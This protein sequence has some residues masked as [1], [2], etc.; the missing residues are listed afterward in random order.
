MEG[1]SRR[2]DRFRTLVNYSPVEYKGAGLIL[3]AEG[4]IVNFM[5]LYLRLLMVK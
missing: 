5:G 3:I 4:N 2:S 1:R